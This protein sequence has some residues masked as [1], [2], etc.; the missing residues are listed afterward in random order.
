M[1]RPVFGLEDLFSKSSGVPGVV[2]RATLP[3]SG[4]LAARFD[5]AAGQEIVDD[6][7]F[8]AWVLVQSRWAGVSDVEVILEQREHDRHISVAV[9]SDEVSGRWLP[10]LR[11]VRNATESLVGARTRTLSL[12][13]GCDSSGPK[14]LTDAI[15]ARIAFA[16]VRKELTLDFD[17]AVM[18]ASQAATL[19]T[20]IHHVGEQLAAHPDVL[21]SG[22]EILPPAMRRRVVMELNPPG[23]RPDVTAVGARYVQALR[24]E[25]TERGGYQLRRRGRDVRRARSMVGCHRRA[26]AANRPESGRRR[27]DRPAALT[28]RNSIDSRHSESRRG[29]LTARLGVPNGAPCFHAA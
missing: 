8:A 13:A 22:I 5:Q 19:L 16:P 10:R 18:E 26:L 6:L 17:P 27:R 1:S 24:R 25:A 9:P 7:L 23:V 11:E 28:G 2:Q 3:L 20:V 15:I 4:R 21:L 12:W 14:P 29:V